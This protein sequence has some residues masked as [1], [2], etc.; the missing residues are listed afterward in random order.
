MCSSDLILPLSYF[1][2]IAVT[3][4]AC[5]L[6]LSQRKYAIEI[7]ERA[8]MSSC[9]PSPTSVDTKPKLNANSSTPY[10]DPSHYRSLARAFQYLTFMRP[11]IAYAMQQVCLFMHDP[12]EEYI[13][14]LKRIVHYIQGTLNHGLHLYLSSTSTLLSYTDAD[15]GT[16]LDARCSTSSY[17]VF[18]GDNLISWSAKRQATLSRSSVEA[19]YRGIANVTSESCWL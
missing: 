19:K 14:A 3:H 11:D 1:L 18:L 12:R 10:A 2:G 15:W 6:F 8:D 4:H 17:C 13:Y 9:K 7:I 16:C 5:S